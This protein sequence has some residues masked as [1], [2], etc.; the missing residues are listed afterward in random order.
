MAES[1]EMEK[2]CP[3]GTERILI[4][5]D[6]PSIAK[7]ESRL[8][9]RFGYKVTTCTSSVDALDKFLVDTDDF[10]LVITD[11]VMPVM[12]GDQLAKEMLRINPHLPVIL[13]TGFSQEMTEDEMRKLGIRKFV[14][15]PIKFEILAQMVRDVLDGE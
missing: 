3:T 13:C 14:Q 9:E 11:M 6:E 2:D 8:L 10:D 7:L 1:V 5:D 4:V 15:K 12:N